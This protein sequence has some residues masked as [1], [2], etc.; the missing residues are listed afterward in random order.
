MIR[1]GVHFVKAFTSAENYQ[2]MAFAQ[3]AYR[4]S[5]PDIET[6]LRVQSGNS[7][8]WVT[9]TGSPATPSPMPIG[10]MTGKS[11]PTSHSTS[12]THVESHRGEPAPMVSDT[13]C[14]RLPNGRLSFGGYP[15][16]YSGDKLV[17]PGTSTDH[18]DLH[19]SISFASGCHRPDFDVAAKRIKRSY[20]D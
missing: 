15:R 2:G 20:R 1:D 10:P 8:I 16:R 7:A 13:V 6:C 3:F 11:T 5:P 9:L 17:K 14:P 12:S 4:N 19:S 18:H